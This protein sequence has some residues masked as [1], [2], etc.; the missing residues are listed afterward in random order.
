MGLAFDI[1][2]G[3]LVLGIQ[4]VEL[5]I[6]A[7]LSRDPGIDRAPDDLAGQRFSRP[8]GLSSPP[9]VLSR[10]PKKRGPLQRVP[11]MAKAIAE[12]LSY[13]VPFHRK[14]SSTTIARWVMPSHSRDKI[15]PAFSSTCPRS[16]ATSLAM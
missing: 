11:V 4:R 5:L 13:R 10:R 7:V 14:P 9:T 12:R 3:S 2:T 1:G 6:E 8:H 16:K 15:V